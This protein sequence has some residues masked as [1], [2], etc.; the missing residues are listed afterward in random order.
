MKN[1][2]LHSLILSAM[3]AA[4]IS[5]LAQ[6][7]IP[8]PL[9]PITGQTLAIGL[10]ATILGKKYGTYSVLVYLF[11][12]AV[13]VPVFSGMTAGLSVLIGPTG[14][15]L[16]GFIPSAFMIGL[17]L[18]RFGYTVKHAVFA[19]LIGMGIT[20]TFGTI[21]LKLSAELTWTAAIAA[22]VT[23]FLI[24]GVLKAFIASYLGILIRQRLQSAKLLRFER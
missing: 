13:G 4:I 11:I 20:L 17:Y 5:V 2:T 18:E 7:F 24:A 16:I 1:K 10:A 6:L 19:N 14:G 22:G 9:V 8:F 21:W 15:Y 23:P 12:G 3:F